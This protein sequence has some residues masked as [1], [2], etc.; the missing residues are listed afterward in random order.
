MKKPFYPQDQ[1][2]WYLQRPDVVPLRTDKET[3]IIVI[4]GGMAGL[5]AAQAFAK[6]GKKVILLEAYYCGAGA[7][8]K[9]SGFITSNGELSFYE[10]V[11]RYGAEGGKTIWD[12]LENYGLDHIRKNIKH[13]NIKCDYTEQDSLEVASSQKAV[14]TVRREAEYLARFGYK[15][16]F[17]KKEDMP[18]FLGTKRYYGGVLYPKSF[19]MN[20]YS[21]CQA[22]K[23][24]L[25]E[26][27][28]EIYEET[29]ALSLEEN[30]VTTLH[31]T[32]KADSIIVCADRFIPTLGKLTKEMYHIQSFIVASQVL[33]PDLIQQLFPKRR[34][35]VWDTDL[36]YSY[37]RMTG[38][39]LLVGGGLHAKVL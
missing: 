25:L 22:M 38:D 33:P 26:E 30:R 20:T 17:I 10:F 16:D 1:T 5:T 9:S 36:V 19:G 32:V 35:M 29:P 27:G 15:T 14:K 11:Q 21:Y 3:E 8:G 24:I 13:Y 18:S 34:L 28:V 39:R 4:G 6:R 31:G 7:S 2:F 23:N 37:Y 12:L